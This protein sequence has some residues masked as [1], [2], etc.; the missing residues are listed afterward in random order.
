MRA[1]VSAGAPKGSQMVAYD[2]SHLTQSDDQKVLGPI[3]DDEALLLFALIRTMRLK[4]VLE[5]GGLEGYSARNFLKA[6]GPAGTLYTVDINPVPSLAANHKVLTKNCAALDRND[7]DGA[8]LDLI[9]I[10]CHLY[11]EQMD[12]IQRLYNERAMTDETVIALHDTGLHPA[13]WVSWSY[14]VMGGWVHQPVERRMVNDLRAAGFD[15]ISFH[16]DRRP[17]GEELAFRH[18]LT[19]MQ[20]FKPLSV[21]PWTSE[22]PASDQDR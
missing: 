21:R 4:R 7:L 3:Q 1:K 17:P 11:G 5:I 9:F 19:I 8:Q 13:K 12:M 6:I 16:M 10:D 20:R 14:E 18:G 22:P 15:A 2:L